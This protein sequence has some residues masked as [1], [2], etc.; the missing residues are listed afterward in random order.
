MAQNEWRGKAQNATPTHQNPKNLA[1]RHL[2]KYVQ[3]LLQH[4]PGPSVE[5]FTS[6]GPVTRA[7]Y[8]DLI[9]HHLRSGIKLKNVDCSVPLS[10]YSMMMLDHTLP[11]WHLRE[12]RILI[13]GVSSSTLAWTHSLCLWYYCATHGSSWWTVSPIWLRRTT[14]GAWV[15]MHAIKGIFSL[16]IQAFVKC[17]D[18]ITQC[19]PCWKM[20][21][22]YQAYLHKISW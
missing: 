7:C 8:C 2:A 17:W 14:A 5:H 22:L 3:T 9:T 6:K 20:T 19:G 21:K 4:H 12:W 13:S 11:M 18:H 1:H 15:A 10:Y 16:G